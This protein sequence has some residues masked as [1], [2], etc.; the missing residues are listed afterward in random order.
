M[1]GKFF[2]AVGGLYGFLSV[3]LGAVGAHA[4]KPHATPDVMSIYHTAESYSF[5]HALALVGAGMLSQTRSS[6]WLKIS[7][8][9]F[10]VGTLLFCG[11]LYLLTLAG[12]PASLAPFGGVLLMLGWLALA[13]GALRP[14]RTI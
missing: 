2:I 3:V 11:S 13:L 14:A 5:Y 8:G 12:T 10:A 1:S 4:L 9:C 7:G 6:I